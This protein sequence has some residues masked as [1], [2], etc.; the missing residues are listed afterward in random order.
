M[1]S[2]RE[3]ALLGRS[4]AGR[5]AVWAMVRGRRGIPRCRHRAFRGVRVASR[6]R[7]AGSTSG[8]AHRREA[9]GA[10]GLSPR[11]AGAWLLSN[12]LDHLLNGDTFQWYRLVQRTQTGT[13]EARFG[14]YGTW[15]P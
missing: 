6:R 11:R 10:E 3:P 14:D 5:V 1:A 12:L 13:H 8:L 9:C 15:S 2:C 7:S 4:L